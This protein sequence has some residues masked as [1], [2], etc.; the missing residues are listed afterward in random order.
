MKSSQTIPITNSHLEITTAVEPEVSIKSE[1]VFTT[2]ALKESPVVLNSGFQATFSLERQNAISTALTEIGEESS[3]GKRKT[4]RKIRP[5][6]A[7]NRKQKFIWNFDP[8]FGD[9]EHEAPTHEQ[10]HAVFEVLKAHLAKQ[11]IYIHLDKNAHKMVLSLTPGSSVTP[12]DFSIDALFKTILSQATDNELAIAAHKSMCEAYPYYVNGM[13]TVGKV[14]NYHDMRTGPLDKLEKAIKPAGLW[15]GRATAFMA[16]LNIIYD[17]NLARS[18]SQGLLP[19][20]NQPNAP[21]FV[22]GPLSLDFLKEM[23]WEDLFEYLMDLPKVNVKTAACILAFNLQYPIFAVDTHAFRLPWMLG[24]LP[25]LLRHKNDRVEAC[26]HLDF[27]IPDD[28]KYGL[29]QAFWHHGQHCLRCSARGRQGTKEWENCHCPLERYIVRR[30]DERGNTEMELQDGEIS[31]ANGVVAPP[32]KR[33]SRSKQLDDTTPK[34]VKTEPS[35]VPLSK[36]TPEEA[37]KKG[38]ELQVIE[39]DD[40]FG[41][42]RTNVTKK[43]SQWRKKIDDTTEKTTFQ[44][45]I[46]ETISTRAQTNIVI[47]HTDPLAPTPLPDLPESKHTSTDHLS[48]VLDS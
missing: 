23:T 5:D 38:Y 39:I 26:M 21:D 47:H 35:L 43:K 4:R 46:K 32:R 31:K 42:E 22:P 9:E 40:N 44:M 25:K 16:I 34:R 8:F 27:H 45:S 36:M 6:L 29:H 1:P 33:K 7:I 37:K 19:T 15:R 28:L 18:M 48:Q 30:W 24:W 12:W 3:Q 14:P 10:C 13:R 17:A 41:A 11:A 20:I 2:N